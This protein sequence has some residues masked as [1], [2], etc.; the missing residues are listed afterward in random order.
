MTFMTLA[1]KKNSNEITVTEISDIAD[2][3]RKTFYVY[4]KGANGIINEIEDDII[5]EFVCII[6]KQDIIKIILEPNLMFNIFTEII[7]K[8]INF[9]TLLINSSLIDTMFEKIK[10]VIREVLS[11]L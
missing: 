2:I 8:D 5:K 11:S 9:F 7:N 1:A 6:N 4:Y 3:N 10:N